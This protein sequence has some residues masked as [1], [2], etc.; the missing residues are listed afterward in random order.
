MCWATRSAREIRKLRR[1]NSEL[2]RANEDTTHCPRR[3]E[4]D[5]AR[6]L[7][8][9]DFIFLAADSH[10]AR[11]VVNVIAHQYLIPVVQMGT[12]IDVDEITGDVGGIRTNVRLI[13]PYSGCLRCNGRI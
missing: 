9:C 10:L 13:L 3:A 4:P 8:D 12:R 1:E 7:V 6:Q 2:R 5:A 11:M